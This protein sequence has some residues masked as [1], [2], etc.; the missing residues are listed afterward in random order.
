MSLD[1][2]L[3]AWS[4]GMDKYGLFQEDRKGPICRGFF[5]DVNQAK[6]EAQEL[7]NRDGITYFVY[8]F[9]ICR[10]V[11]IFRPLERRRKPRT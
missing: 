10:E 6:V 4:E 7:A 9:E 3:S 8:S 11:A 5:S 1:D 2:G